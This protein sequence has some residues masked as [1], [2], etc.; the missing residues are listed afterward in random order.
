[1]QTRIAGNS[2]VNDTILECFELIRND[3]VERQYRKKFKVE[4]A[5]NWQVMNSFREL[6]VAGYFAATGHAVTLARFDGQTPDWLVERDN[7]RSL[8]EVFTK[9]TDLATFQTLDK[10]KRLA[11]GNPAN[12]ICRLCDTVRE[13]ESKYRNLAVR[14]GL[15]LIVAS[16]L[17]ISFMASRSELRVSIPLAMAALGPESCMSG[18]LLYERL[19]GAHHFDW[20]DIVDGQRPLRVASGATLREFCA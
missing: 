13:K 7:V 19:N 18:C 16:A 15:K 1:M 6:V 12:D 5:D 20:I 8:V 17:D 2:V 11:Y 9:Y 14:E 4:C 10:G 3:A